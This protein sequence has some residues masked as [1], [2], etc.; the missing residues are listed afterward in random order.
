MKYKRGDIIW[1]KNENT[2]WNCLQQGIRPAV[3]IS[4]DMGNVYGSVMIVA[5]LTERIKRLDIPTHVVISSSPKTSVVLLEQ[6]ST[7][8]EEQVKGYAGRGCVTPSEMK[9]IDKALRVSLGLTC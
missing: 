1:I 9:E 7:V 8:A 6:I 3:V 5:Y 4:N 2:G